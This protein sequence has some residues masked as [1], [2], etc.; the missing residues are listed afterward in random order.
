MKYRAKSNIVLY[1]LVL[2]IWLIT[3]LLKLKYNGFVFGFDY[4]LYH[5]DGALYATRAFDWSGY[6]E[7]ESAKIVKKLAAKSPDKNGIY[8]KDS[9]ILKTLPTAYVKHLERL[10]LVLNKKK[11]TM[12]QKQRLIA[13]ILDNLAINFNI[14]NSQIV[15]SFNMFKQQAKLKKYL[16]DK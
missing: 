15:K 10:I 4:G 5:P 3:V 9:R 2:G 12:S 7:T 6:T 14:T 16:K 13:D 11:H 8:V 1:F